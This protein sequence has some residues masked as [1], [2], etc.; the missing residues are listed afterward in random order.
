M[1]N[2]S[3]W[4][5]AGALCCLALWVACEQNTP[6]ADS[7]AKPETANPEAAKPAEKAQDHGD[8]GHDHGHDHAGHDHAAA[9]ATDAAKPAPD[10]A[11]PAAEP[12]GASLQLVGVSFTVPAGWHREEVK[13]S[14]MGPV[15]VFKINND[16]GACEVRITHFENMK[17]MD[18]M[19][20]NRW[21][22][23]VIQ[24]D[25]SPYTREAAK[26]ESKE[27]GDVKFTVVDLPG[28]VTASMGGPDEA[29][30]DGRMIAAIV[31]HGRGP[32]YVRVYGPSKAMEL[33]AADVHAF[34]HSA[35]TGS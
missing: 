23:M 11:K 5:M 13:S 28:T 30:P 17:G 29:I 4:R 1:L 31:D 14:P 26:V 12:G 3:A 27:V 2:R 16:G 20:I 7:G 24:P 34:L 15:A 9:P 22:G 35:K 21:L 10:A 25:G 19:N 32:H 18:D 8:H 6:P 33:A